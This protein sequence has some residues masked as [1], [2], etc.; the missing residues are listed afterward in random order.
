MTKTPVEPPHASPWLSAWL[1]PRD[2]ITRIVAADPH[3]HVLLIASL[4]F[5]SNVVVQ[6]VL[7]GWGTVLRDWRVVAAILIAGAVV[8]IVGLYYLGFFL[9]WSG[10]VFGG[11][12]APAQVRAALAWGQLPTLL[13]AAIC[14]AILI[15]LKLTGAHASDTLTGVLSLIVAVSGL[16]ALIM[17]WLMLASV[18]EFGFW[19][20]AGSSIVGWLVGWLIVM[21]V[22]VV[23]FRT[24]VFQHFNI[25]SGAMTPA[26]QVG[27][28]MFV[29]KYAYG[30]THYSLPF[31]PPLFSGRILASEPQR[32]DVVVY[33]LPKD[34]TVDYVSR[35]V[36]LPN[37]RIQMKNG[38]LHINGT[39]VERTRAEDFAMTENRRMTSVKRWRE[40]LPNGVSHE[41]LDAIDNGF[42]DNT[43]EYKV[44]PGHY[45][46]MGDNR[47]N[48]TDSRVLNRVGYV[49]F[50]NLIGRAALIFMSMK[51]DPE[52]GE[53]V[54]SFERFGSVR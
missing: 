28:Y 23:P 30:Y 36:G 45:F 25:P 19:R 21:L 42:Y 3:R 43:P 8:G 4:G 6:L 20:T 35:I 52:S 31:S 39:P 2:T 27:D 26:L 44:P 47:D 38:L 41:T 33:R 48:A 34:D 50:E 15:A 1:S 18:Q 51:T 37:D 53:R 16:W 9:R 5:I 54:A 24:F 11:R 13:F 29:S 17:T 32:G 22:L 14:L 12:A 49:P 40:T 10:K 7:A 46:M